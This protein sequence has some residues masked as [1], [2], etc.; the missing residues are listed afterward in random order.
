MLRIS[1]IICLSSFLFATPV[2]ADAPTPEKSPEQLLSEGMRSLIKA[3][4]LFMQN[5][6]QFGEPYIID[7]GDIV[8]PRIQPKNPPSEPTE[9]SEEKGKRQI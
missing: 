7:N 9:K 2:R 1:A 8:I 5:L 3:M 6:P 4:K